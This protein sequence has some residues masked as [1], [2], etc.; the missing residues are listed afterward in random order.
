MP[1]TVAM[2]ETEIRSLSRSYTRGM[3]AVLVGVARQ[4]TAA[5]AARVAAANSVL[6]RGWGKA[7]QMH[8]VDGDIK[9]TIRH[10]LEHID[11]RPVIV[12]GRCVEL[13]TAVVQDNEDNPSSK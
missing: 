11:D 2:T 3:L 9:V 1:R 10:I 7:D 6:D 8:T 5:P 12:D 4:K 13:D